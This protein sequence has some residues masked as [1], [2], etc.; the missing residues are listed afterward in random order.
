VVYL[1]AR[2]L[3]EPMTNPVSANTMESSSGSGREV[4]PSSRTERETLLGDE[5]RKRVQAV[6]LWVW[7]IRGRMCLS[8]WCIYAPDNPAS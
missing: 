8:R 5:Q 2:K 1:M 7:H 4:C 6:N 3:A